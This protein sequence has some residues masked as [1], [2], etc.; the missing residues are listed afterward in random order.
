MRPAAAGADH[1]FEM[2]IT[3]DE[4]NCVRVFDVF[5]GGL[6][7]NIFT[8]SS[9]VGVALRPAGP[10]GSNRPAILYVAEYG[11]HRVQALDA[12]T[13]TH[14]RYFG[15]GTAGA[16]MDQFNR[17][18]AVAIHEAEAGSG[19]P[20]LLFVADYC[21]HRIQ[22][23]HAESG[24][25]VR[26]IGTSGKAGNAPGQFNYPSG[27]ALRPPG[28]YG[29]GKP[30]ILFVADRGN[31]RIQ[32]V[33]ADTGAHLRYYGTGVQGAGPDQLS[34]P[35]GV[36]LLEPAA[37][38]AQPTLLAVADYSNHRVQIYNADSGAVVRTLGTTGAHGAALSQL[39]YPKGVT[40]HRRADGATLVFVTEWHYNNR[41]Q[42]FVL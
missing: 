13:D 25:H 31:H 5:G 12:N 35:F 22:V 21:N 28:P 20:S 27:L 26:T 41:V 23:F 16:G 38:S 15:T 42:V 37:G 2:F 11:A 10:D 8:G 17:P 33:N 40:M 4:Q 32:A 34:N 14:L 9:P 39:Y 6:L 18:W 30:L 24:A 36:A 19:Q 3:C 7:R 29:S 1:R